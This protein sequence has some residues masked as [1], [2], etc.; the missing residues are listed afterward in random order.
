MPIYERRCNWCQCKFQHL[1]K[2]EDRNK[3]KRCPGCGSLSTDPIMSATQ[4]NFTFAD[5]SARKE[6]R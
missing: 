5:K 1:S 2:V 4:T 3:E 6:R